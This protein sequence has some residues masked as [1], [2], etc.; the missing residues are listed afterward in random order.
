MCVC[1]C[2]YICM[3]VCVDK[4]CTYEQSTLL[5]DIHCIIFAITNIV[6]Y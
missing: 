3:Y 4:R 6:Y 5:T 2:V 1:V